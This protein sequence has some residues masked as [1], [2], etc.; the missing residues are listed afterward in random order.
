MEP[1]FG[2]PGE[3]AFLGDRDEIAQM[4]KFHDPCLSGMVRSLQ[5]LSDPLQVH[6]FQRGPA[7][8]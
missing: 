2:R 3:A 1:P 8:R 4:A 7:D 6:L 5:S